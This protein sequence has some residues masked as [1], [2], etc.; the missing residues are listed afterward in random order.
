MEV[1][2]GVKRLGDDEAAIEMNADVNVESRM[3]VKE[4]VCRDPEPAKGT[5]EW[6]RASG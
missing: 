3:V 2:D 5:W 6:R 4:E 1:G